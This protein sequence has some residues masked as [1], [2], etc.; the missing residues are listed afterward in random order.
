MGR[1]KAARPSGSQGWNDNKW[2]GQGGWRQQPSSSQQ[3]WDWGRSKWDKD[4]EPEF[5]TYT[6]MA[7]DKHQK[8]AAT[9]SEGSDGK[10]TG[11]AG[12]FQKLLTT[13]RKTE[14][15]MRKAEEERASAQARWQKFQEKLQRTFVKERLQFHKDMTRLD[16]ELQELQESQRT[17]YQDLQTAIAHP[18][19]L[20]VAK[21]E[22]EPIPSDIANEWDQLLA[23]CDEPKDESMVEALA[24]Q[25][26][27]KLQ[28]I[29]APR[30]PARTTVA[31]GSPMT[32]PCT[33]RVGPRLAVDQM[34]EKAIAA[35]RGATGHE[36]E[37]IADPYLTSP[38]TNTGRPSPVLETRKIKGSTPRQGIKLKGRR[39]IP[40]PKRGTTL[41]AKL[42]AA[43]S[44]AATLEEEDAEILSDEED[45]EVALAALSTKAAER[46]GKGSGAYGIHTA[47]LMLPAYLGG[48]SRRLCQ[49]QGHGTPTN[50]AVEWV[51]PGLRIAP[52]QPGDSAWNRRDY[53]EMDKLDVT[54]TP[55]H[56][57]P[58]QY[59]GPQLVD[60]AELLAVG[61]P[62]H[63]PCM[64]GEDI[65]SRRL[66]QRL[67]HGPLMEKATE[68]RSPGLSRYVPENFGQDSALN[69]RVYDVL[70]LLEQWG[71]G[72]GYRFSQ[73]AD[74]L[75]QWSAGCLLTHLA[76]C[77][78]STFFFG[79]SGLGGKAARKWSFGGTPGRLC[80]TLG[81]IAMVG[82]SLVPTQA[83][84][85]R[86]T[87]RLPHSTDLEMWLSGQDTIREQLAAA[88]QRW[89]LTR[90][91]Q[92]S[93]GEAP[94]RVYTTSPPG[95]FL[96]P[97]LPTMAEVTLH[98]T[99]WLAAVYYQSEIVDL[100]IPRP[101]TV[102]MLT[103]ALRQ[104]C[105]VTPDEFDELL[106]TVPQLGD[107]HGSFIAQP[108]WMRG[109]DKTTMVM[110]AR[111]LGGTV[112]AFYLSGRLNH[113]GLLHSLPEF[114]DV[115]LD[116]YLY[117][118]TTPLELGH[119]AEA[120]PGGV[121]K[122]VLSGR[123][124]RWSDMLEARLDRPTRWNPN[125][126]PPTQLEGLYSVYQTT[127][128]QVIE[129]IDDLEYRDQ[130]EI[131][132]EALGLEDE[133]VTIFQ[134]TGRIPRLAHGGRT[135]YDQIA[136]IETRTMP[137]QEYLI[138]FA[139]LRPL[140]CF[141]QWIQLETNIFAP[142]SYVSDLQLAGTDGWTVVVV[143][144][145]RL[146]QDRLKVQH[147]ETLVF[148][149]QPPG[150][151][152]SE[153]ETASSEASSSTYDAI[154]HSSDF[155]STTP[156]G[157]NDPRRGPPPPRPV[158][159]SRSP[160]RGGERN[161]QLTDGTPSAP[162]EGEARTIQLHAMVGPPCYDMTQNCVSFPHKACDVRRLLERWPTTYG[163]TDFEGV[164]FKEP[165]N[166]A[167]SDLR[168]RNEVWRG[169]RDGELP[170]LHIYTDG[171]W[172]ET[173]GL[174][175]FAMIALLV[176]ASATALY[177]TLGAQTHGNLDC[178][179][180]FE[181]APALKNEQ[182]AIATSLL[183]L[184]QGCNYMH[185]GQILIFF[186]CYAAGWPA[187][188]TWSP[189]NRFSEQTRAIEQFLRRLLKAP[190]K[191]VHAKA[192]AGNPFNEMADVLAGLVAKNT[193]EL[194]APPAEVCTLMQQGDFQWLP[195]LFDDAV[196]PV[197][198][199]QG[200]V[201]EDGKTWARPALR[202]D[203]L[204]PTK[205]SGTSKDGG[206]IET[207]LLCLNAQTLSGKCRYYEDQL[208]SLGYNIACFQETKSAAGLCASKRFLR[209]AASSDKYWGTAVWISKTRGLYSCGG[210]P[211]RVQAEDIHVVHESPRLLVL[212][213]RT[214]E[215][216]VVV[217]SGHCPHAAQPQEA[218]NFLSRLQ[219]L[220]WPY[221][222][223]MAI[224]LGIDL[225]GRVPLGHAG[226]TGDLSHGE[227][228]DNGRGM[229]VA[230]RAVNLWLPSTYSDFHVGPTTTYRQANGAEHR[231]DYIGVGG[232]MEIN[233]VCSWVEEEFDTANPNEDHSAI[234]LDVTAAT[235]AT[236]G[237]KRLHRVRYD[238][239]K[240]LT[241]QGRAII[242]EGLRAY[243]PPS[244]EVH[245]DDHCQ[246]LQDYLHALMQEH[247]ARAEDG[248]GATYITQET[249]ELRRRKLGLKHRA[250]HRRDLWS[251]LL[252]RAFLQWR[253]RDDY[254]VV[255]LLS[256]QAILYD[257]VAGA[258]KWATARIKKGIY[259]AKANY[260]QGIVHREGDKAC[261]V[262]HKAKLAGVG[263]RQARPVS[264]PLPALKDSTGRIA[265]SWEDRD[266][267]WLDHFGK[268][269]MGHLVTTE[270]Y[271]GEENVA[272]CRDEEIPWAH[273]DLPTLLE[274]EE[275]MRRASRRKAVGLDGLPGEVLAAAPAEMALAA[276]PLFFKSMAALHQPV[277][278]RGGI[279]QESWKRAGPIDCPQNY[280]SLFISSQLGKCYHR[281]LRRRVA[282]YVSRGLHEFHLGAK[283]QSPVLYPALYIQAFLRRAQQLH[284]SAA[285]LFI[286]TTAAYYRV[287]R[288]LSVGQVATDEAVAKV[289]KFFDLS[290]EDTY[291][292]A[293]LIREGGMM[294]DAGIPVALRHMAKDLLHRS[295]FIT[296]HGSDTQLCCTQAG[297]RPGE[298][299]ADIVFSFVLGK[300]LMQ[301][302][303]IATAEELL[304]SLEYS[305]DRGP[306]MA[307][308]PPLTG[309]E[310]LLAQ[311]CTWADDTAIPLSDADPLILVN[312][313][314]RLASIVLDYFLRH[315][316]QPNL[317]PKK[318]AFIMAIRGKGAQKVRRQCFAE[319]TNT[320]HLRD[321]DL[322]VTIASQYVHL[323]GIVNTEMKLQQEARRRLSMAKA[324]FDSGRA[325]LYTNETIP[326]K[327]RASLFNTSIT[328]T[329]FNLALW[330]TGCSA[331]Q[332][333]DAGFSRL[334]RG[335]MA[336]TYKGELL[337]KVATPAV[338]I[339]TGVPPLE[340]LARKARISL[341]CS[342][343][344]TGPRA[345]WAVLQA[346]G[347]WLREVVDDLRWLSSQ[348]DNWPALDADSWDR[349]VQLLTASNGWIKRQ[350]ARRI[351]REEAARHLAFR[352]AICHWALLRRAKA[353]RHKDEEIG[354]DWTC[355]PCGRRLRTKAALGA[356]FF[357]V[358][359]RR[360]KYRA[361]V[362]GTR[363]DACGKEFWARN[364]LAVHLRD[365]AW[366][367]KQLHHAG[368]RA[369]S[370]APGIGSRA[371][372][373]QEEEDFT[374]SASTQ[375][376]D[377]TYTEG[378]NIWDATMQRAYAEL[379]DNLLTDG[380]PAG[381]EYIVAVIQAVFMRF[382]LYTYEMAEIATQV[383]MEAN[384]LREAEVADYWDDEVFKGLCEALNNFAAYPWT[385]EPTPSGELETVTLRAFLREVEDVNWSSLL[386]AARDVTPDVSLTLTEDWEVALSSDSRLMEVATVASSYWGMLP[387]QLRDA[388][389]H[390]LDGHKVQLR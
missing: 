56:F 316:M 21:P 221:R 138:I 32:P 288:E 151:T 263:G 236:S 132:Q 330:T 143:G 13:A 382:P 69:R 126:D 152:T 348:G 223:A 144:G 337:Y 129:E 313:S 279:L 93:G 38:S 191:F 268:Q 308:T 7:E 15:R 210:K 174:G 275:A 241:K 213:I 352:T 208:D 320:L 136:V 94:P 368:A 73:I 280:R 253:N 299:W 28:G 164:E 173:Q 160:R 177:S 198:G 103:D 118:R 214:T 127:D 302:V 40:T 3:R 54:G 128:D 18:E 148:S 161:E 204:I 100:E 65:T 166:A 44:R 107:F 140:G 282:P 266:K 115:E 184:L 131:A 249:W 37:L 347:E 59:R 159:R 155:S 246:H 335:L 292:F 315:G 373:R 274:V 340:A 9:G 116:F 251:T 264:R 6:M 375:V 374:L 232:T 201:W 260:L 88:E 205:T 376:Q 81:I 261:D 235:T 19:T 366:C 212:A 98:V 45:E 87:A 326:L 287:I 200:F 168:P 23:A 231:I 165:T 64:L 230:A 82:D 33:T 97:E 324:A 329:F 25:L 359:H 41:A 83:V 176:T 341:L 207:K 365:S 52:Y 323:G 101:F 196:L 42:E 10:K 16:T 356:H 351:G 109:S 389:D 49:R 234:A 298:T 211:V 345:L 229:L 30:T 91:L 278:W 51:K 179:W 259:S 145:E 281:L 233:E 43:R 358:H 227:A 306:F 248:P 154:P 22:T 338:H 309:Q 85:R 156:P 317:K 172:A 386:P 379:C 183:W 240:M 150:S 203:Q 60:A 31:R 162:D 328:A 5:P 17:A 254:D 355:R 24:A 72:L 297:S 269:E 170:E 285:V 79:F 372:R 257:V 225:N 220:L 189:I 388:W 35:A 108:A 95:E 75:Q 111:E 319:G 325:L 256:K 34:M 139:D 273:D 188:G 39:P 178:P 124:C 67:C 380:L 50:D 346:E 387:D 293:T 86:A 8:E 192:H 1:S 381:V 271:L 219:E 334:L 130:S 120:R 237:R 89:A 68:P 99:L 303:E 181:A 342:M 286:D 344:R 339:M 222:G 383:A 122:A 194:V 195:H 262:L 307:Q 333:L 193:L 350:V 14:V 185:F 125:F 291:E 137:E 384:E 84:R 102:P 158:N 47:E 265:T 284:H 238:A 186:D 224:F 153:E 270:T 318:T 12:G 163:R 106:P 239:D 272:I 135:I 96:E 377:P 113:A 311:D 283:Q 66:H 146:G 90:P 363:C 217:A 327:T 133:H 29:L 362:E 141:P 367:A 349:W 332:I 390:A 187:D 61:P 190:I 371:W 206:T 290:P 244:W 121:V 322:K 301:I 80:Y 119:T 169:L 209:L 343:A 331:W 157:P 295:W 243:S 370:I 117:G 55:R 378:V 70:D 369:Q 218:V 289:F 215:G 20:M 247:F 304:T 167:L 364:K 112:Y 385:R 63:D 57:L 226:V 58:Q 46:A 202:P 360:A 114:Q 62:Q 300:I 180:A 53:C 314:R 26:G 258:V 27:R 92:H 277:Q 276:F 255:A 78:T 252:L 199:G 354:S 2:Q 76:I 321:L 105:S 110:D 182:I 353:R 267:I 245:P 228:D 4:E 175:G 361:V 216:Q 74:I 197:R 11:L 171:S 123:Y 312:K 294:G 296:R 357:K 48:V 250:R 77:L 71:S 305:P 36:G 149:L 134:P 310:H 242:A 336:K 147:L 104:A 142:S